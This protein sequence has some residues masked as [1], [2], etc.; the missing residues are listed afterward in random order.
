[1]LTGLGRQCLL[2]WA[3]SAYSAG[4]TVLNGLGRQCLMGWA[5][6]GYWAGPT[7]L[8]ALGRQCLLGWADSAYLAGP[9]VL[10]RLGRQ[11]LSRGRRTVSHGRGTSA[12]AR[13]R[14][15]G[16]R[17]FCR[18]TG[19]HVTWKR[20]ANYGAEC[21]RRTKTNGLRHHMKEMMPCD[22]GRMMRVIGERWRGMSEE[23]K[24]SWCTLAED[25]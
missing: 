24:D 5:D 14:H 12:A 9:T 16:G 17:S 8:T 18:T 11:G 10:T 6:N 13:R 7:V 19:R 20:S 23:D 4:P 3:D 2:G 1:M 22:I 21:L 15:G 25:P